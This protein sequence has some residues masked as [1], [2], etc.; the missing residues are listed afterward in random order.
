[1]AVNDK[2]ILRNTT[3]KRVNVTLKVNP[4]CFRGGG[5]GELRERGVGESSRA[6]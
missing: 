4:V 5:G 3:L 6:L 2:V 1:M